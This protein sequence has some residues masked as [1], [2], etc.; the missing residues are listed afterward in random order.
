MERHPGLA[1]GE[2]GGAK[3][4]QTYVLIANTSAADA[5]VKVTLLF[6]DGVEQSRLVAVGASRRYTVDTGS[7]FPS[8]VGKRFSVLVESQNPET[9][10]NLVVERAMYWNTTDETWGTG[11][12]AVATRLP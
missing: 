2:V 12:N 8:S 10:G 3:G 7:M 9:A 4:I 11:S 1:E 5:T 6:E